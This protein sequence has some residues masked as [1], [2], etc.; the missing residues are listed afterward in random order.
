MVVAQ[1][2]QRRLLPKEYVKTVSHLAEAGG[3]KPL[4]NRE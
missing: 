3:D 2:T 4:L 1:T